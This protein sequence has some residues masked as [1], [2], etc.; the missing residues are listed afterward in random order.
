LTLT[1]PRTDDPLAGAAVPTSTGANPSAAL[2]SHLQR[3]YAEQ[4]S[5]VGIPDHQFEGRRDLKSNE[6]YRA[7]IDGRLAAWRASRVAGKG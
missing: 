5:Q 4:L 1:V 6:D 2:S 3:M 7:Y